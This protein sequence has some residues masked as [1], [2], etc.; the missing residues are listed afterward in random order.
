MTTRCGGPDGPPHRNPARRMTTDQ[1]TPSKTQFFHLPPERLP[2]G[3]H[4]GGHLDEVTIAY[5]TCGELA[6]DASNAIL[7]FH[8]LTGSQHLAGWT[9]SVDGVDKWNDECRRGWWSDFVGPGLAIDT[10]RYFVIGANYLGGCYGSTGPSSLD[11]ATGLPYGSTFPELRFVD[12]VDTQMALLDH[13]GIDRLHAVV[14]G[15][16]GGLLALLTATRHPER[17]GTVIPI[18]AGLRATELQ[19]LHNFE[20]TVAI[21][22]DPDFAGGDYYDG[23]HPDRGLTLARM[24]GHKTFVSLETMA[25]RAQDRVDRGWG[26]PPGYRLSHPLESYIWAQGRRFLE[27]FDANTYL[28]L[29]WMWQ[30][31][32]LLAEAGGDASSL[33]DLF[34]ECTDQRFLVF[35]IDSDVCFYPDEQTQLMRVLKGAGV[36]AMRI[37]VHSDKGHDSFL[38]EP[39]LFA[40]HLRAVLAGDR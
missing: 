26:D 10:D 40:P 39:E 16:T 15:S 13:L 33:V 32:D 11:P 29:M 28:R 7:V 20:Q 27:R 9:E 37:T 19:F 17:V 6:P 36:D 35:S 30:H 8:A 1:P 12:V 4:L 3:L 22:D 21:L 14:G 25:E 2:F 5:E 34:D 31:F 38:L 24:I 23:P 18:A